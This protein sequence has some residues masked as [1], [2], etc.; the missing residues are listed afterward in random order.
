MKPLILALMLIFPQKPSEPET[1]K[2]KKEFIRAT[3]E[4]KIS[5]SKLLPFY[6]A[7]VKRAEDKLALSRKLVSEG[8]M[9]QD[10]CEA[11]ARELDLARQK[12]EETKRAI[13]AADEQITSL[14]SD[15]E[16]IKQYNRARAAEAKVARRSKRCSNW[17]LTARQKSSSRSVSF[18]YRFV[19]QN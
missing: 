1:V 15:E 16:L 9:S 4:Y 2:L 19:C 12:V 3:N 5:L 11:N 7:Y 10:I 6:E 8:S 17:T 18:S 13:A 14:P